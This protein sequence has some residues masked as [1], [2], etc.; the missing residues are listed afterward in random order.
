MGSAMDIIE[1]EGTPGE[2]TIVIRSTYRQTDTHTHV[3]HTCDTHM[4][5]YMCHGYPHTSSISA[6]AYVLY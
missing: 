4:H 2:A 5:A 1:T 6:L 3:I